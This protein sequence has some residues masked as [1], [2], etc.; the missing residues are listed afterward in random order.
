MLRHASCVRQPHLLSPTRMTTRL[1]SLALI[2]N[3]NSLATPATRH[4]NRRTLTMA[5]AANGSSIES[6]L[7]LRR[8]SPPD[9]PSPPEPNAQAE[10]SDEEWEIR[11]GAKSSCLITNK[12]C[13]TQASGRAIRILSQTLPNF[14]STGLC[15]SVDKRTSMAM[16]PSPGSSIPIP[17]MLGHDAKSLG[18]D[19]ESEPLYSSK[20]RLSY[21]PP[22]RLPSPFPETLHVEGT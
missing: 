4:A 10:L 6:Q 19:P 22:A 5:M 20:V 12:K 7:G 16:P 8:S 9:S 21:R 18:E 17:G 1:M 3:G 14:F 2:R 11:T 13:L 15:T